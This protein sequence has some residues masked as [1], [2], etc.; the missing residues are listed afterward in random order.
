MKITL[1]IASPHNKAQGIAYKIAHLL[2]PLF[3]C[4]FLYLLI[5]QC[6]S[7]NHQQDLK[8]R[9]DE[10]N[11]AVLSTKPQTPG[12]LS[13]EDFERQNASMAFINDLEAK[14]R[15]S[16]IE[17][18]GRLEESLSSGVTLIQIVPN[19]SQHSLQVIGL[20]ENITS[21]RGYLNSLLHSDTL[22]EAYLLQQA[23]FK[24]KNHF[25]REHRAIKFN[26]EIQKAF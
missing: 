7:W 22:R 5:T 8:L 23:S 12:N 6:L 15:F 13:T 19:Y 14:D 25:G 24:I 21:L 9:L 10:L 18:L 3:T 2:M 20:A 1:N 11:A 17:L 4:L 16:W 26:I